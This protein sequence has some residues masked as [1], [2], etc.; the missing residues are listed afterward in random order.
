WGGIRVSNAAVRCQVGQTSGATLTIQD[1]G[2]NMTNALNDFEIECNAMFTNSQS[3]N[4][5]AGRTLFYV[6]QMDVAGNT[7]ISITNAGT[8][9]GNGAGHCVIRVGTAAAG[10]SVINQSA[11]R[12]IGPH[13]GHAQRAAVVQT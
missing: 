12:V 7:T 10:T 11:G 5:A 1:G 2:I 13:T 8:I 4:V 6:R 3:W 9:S